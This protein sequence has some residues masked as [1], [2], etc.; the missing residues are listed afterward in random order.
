MGLVTNTSSEAVNIVLAVHGLTKYF[1]VVV[2]RNDVKRLKPDPESIMLAKKKLEAED[3]VMVGDLDLDA[4]AAK[5]AEGFA[6]TVRREI[7]NHE[8][9]EADCIVESLAEVPEIVQSRREMTQCT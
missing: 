6:I 4:S 2:T 1:D 7:G 8:G 3:F 9:S 5:N